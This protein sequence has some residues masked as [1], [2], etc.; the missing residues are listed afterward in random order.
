MRNIQQQAVVP[1][2]S[3][4][5]DRE[6]NGMERR[7]RRLYIHIIH[8]YRLYGQSARVKGIKVYELSVGILSA[9]LIS[10]PVVAY[11]FRTNRVIKI[12]IRRLGIDVIL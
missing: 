10:P 6:G 1:Q 11:E 8:I 4:S 3:F 7:R 5:S 12:G 2:N 9:Y